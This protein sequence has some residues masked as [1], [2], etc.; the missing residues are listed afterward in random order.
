MTLWPLRNLRCCVQF[1]WGGS[2]LT[3]SSFFIRN[4]CHFYS[5][6]H[7][8]LPARMR[9][10]ILQDG[11]VSVCY[12][13]VVVCAHNR[14]FCQ[15]KTGSCSVVTEDVECSSRDDRLSKN[16]SIW[17]MFI[18]QRQLW[19]K[20]CKWNRVSEY[21]CSCCAYFLLPSGLRLNISYPP[22]WPLSNDRTEM[23]FIITPVKASD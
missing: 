3:W 20:F 13:G 4:S 22:I 23:W 21:L 17:R 16:G 15:N 12:R 2:D 8:S 18:T 19:R 6:A 7:P 14:I 1:H 10:S 11:V 9:V 5:N